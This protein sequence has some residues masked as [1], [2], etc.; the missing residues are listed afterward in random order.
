MQW[1]KLKS[2]CIN[3]AEDPRGAR[4]NRAAKS[5]T[6]ASMNINTYFKND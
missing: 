3:T 4:S 2:F 1:Y 6:K 5:A